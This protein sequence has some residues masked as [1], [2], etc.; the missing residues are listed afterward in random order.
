MFITGT[1]IQ[2]NISY[3]TAVYYL[4]NYYN[5]SVFDNSSII[6][7]VK[8]EHRAKIW[9][10][11]HKKTFT[12]P[13]YYIVIGG[14]SNAKSTI[15]KGSTY[16]DY[17]PQLNEAYFKPFWVSWQNGLYR[18]EDVLLLIQRCSYHSR[19]NV[20]LLCTILESLELIIM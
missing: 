19:T 12:T 16:D 9:L 5:S 3:I 4:S 7:K 17:G 11:S 8:G 20:C 18:Q 6:F 14:W 13:S 1:E 2:L 15:R 10:L